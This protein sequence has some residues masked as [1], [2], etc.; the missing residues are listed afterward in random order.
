MEK[1]DFVCM[2][3]ALLPIMIILWLALVFSKGAVQATLLMSFATAAT[4]LIMS[5]IFFVTN[6]WFNHKNK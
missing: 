4:A 2:L 5:W 6:W 3:L 1:G